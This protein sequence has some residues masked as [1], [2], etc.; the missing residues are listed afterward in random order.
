M[1]TTLDT[2][3]KRRDELQKTLDT[4]ATRVKRGENDT[5]FRPLSEM[6]AI[7]ADLDAQIA[8][9]EGGAGPIK[10]LYVSGDK[11]L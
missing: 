4:G 10:R 5:F 3:K 1:T 8:D 7:L 6:M 2:L 11:G 9:L